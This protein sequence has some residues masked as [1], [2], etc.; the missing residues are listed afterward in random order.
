M[1]TAIEQA[2]TEFLKRTEAQQKINPVVSKGD[3]RIVG[4]TLSWRAADYGYEHEVAALGE[5]ATIEGAQNN[6]LAAALRLA[7]IEVAGRTDKATASRKR[8]EAVEVAGGPVRVEIAMH[9]NTGSDEP[10]DEPRQPY[11]GK[12]DDLEDDLVDE[13]IRT[14]ESH[15]ED[16]PPADYHR[17]GYRRNGPTPYSDEDEYD[18]EIPF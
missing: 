2:I 4:V 3:T 10:P 7:G 16:E 17:T 18:D 5:A 14:G 6:A 12:G 8:K 9:N 13:M 1:A 11:V 15:P